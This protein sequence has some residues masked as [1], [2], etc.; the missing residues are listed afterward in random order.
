MPKLPEI[1]GPVS[2]AGAIGTAISSGLHQAGIGDV[3][4]EHVIPSLVALFLGLVYRFAIKWLEQRGAVADEEVLNRAAELANKLV[5]ERTENPPPLEEIRQS[6]A[7]IVGHARS[8]SSNSGEAVRAAQNAEVAATTAAHAA[9]T[10]S[11]QAK[12]NASM[13]SAA[14]QRTAAVLTSGPEPAAGQQLPAV[15]GQTPLPPPED[16]GF[17]D[18]SELSDKDSR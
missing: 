3:D 7:E 6:L 15:P 16:D 13:L 1:G 2:A 17:D 8:S 5:S 9:Q 10:A 4:L 12:A 14:A 11:S 18:D